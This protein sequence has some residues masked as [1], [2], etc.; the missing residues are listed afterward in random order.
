MCKGRGA[1]EQGV[2]ADEAGPW[3]FAAKLCSADGEQGHV[4]DERERLK[5]QVR[6]AFAATPRPEASRIRNSSDGDEPFLLEAEF[7]NIPDWRQLEPSFIDQAPDGFGTA[8]SFFSR[9]AFRYYLPAYRIADLDEALRQAEPLFHLWHG[10]DDE[11]RDRQVNER[12]YGRW[13]WFEAITERFALFSDAEANAIVAYLR[14]KA[15]HDG[16]ARPKIEQA[17]A[18]F[19]L[20]RVG[21]APSGRT[22]S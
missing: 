2:E 4:Y 17:L 22:K 12:R 14:Y 1:A 16:F 18:N 8:L 10:L 3:S 21:E 7:R 9:E 6:E 13:T 15:A 20:T 11:N 19:W 5:A